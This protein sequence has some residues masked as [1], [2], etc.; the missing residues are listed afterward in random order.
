[1]EQEQKET[2]KYEFIYWLKP[3]V[4]EE[5]LKRFANELKNSIENL[6]GKIIK[7]QDL[8]KE[9]LAY[10][11]KHFTD[12]FLN[13]SLVELLPEKIDELKKDLKLNNDILRYTIDR[14]ED[15]E[16]PVTKF[17]PKTI[18]KGKIQTLVSI[19]QKSIEDLAAPLAKEKEVDKQ[20][21]SQQDEKSEE[22]KLKEKKEDKKINLEDVDEKLEKILGSDF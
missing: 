4:S 13:V 5:N 17:E 18:I 8:K 11:I 19:Q 9:Q 7:E 10:P 6:G 21:I 16:K 15:I 12:G 14:A 2:K 22:Q 20:V 3:S 1:M